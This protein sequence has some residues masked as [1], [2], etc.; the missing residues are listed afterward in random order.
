MQIERLLALCK[1][2]VSF[3]FPYM[4][5]VVSNGFLT[6][7]KKLH[8]KDGGRDPT[9]KYREHL[10]RDGVRLVSSAPQNQTARKPQGWL[11][12][13]TSRASSS[14]DL[15]GTSRSDRMRQAKRQWDFMDESEQSRW[16]RAASQSS[17]APAQEERVEAQPGRESEALLLGLRTDSLPVNP[18]AFLAA[19]GVAETASFRSWG[20]T[21]Q[22]SF[23]KRVFVKH[24]GSIGR[25]VSR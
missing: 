9:T 3:K 25:N 4:D 19:T 18:D 8:L 15:S 1:R 10:E 7:C 21:A 5:R 12:F 2:S 20:P 22:E 23:R 6:T 13:A 17:A 14:E 16:E 11:A 24:T